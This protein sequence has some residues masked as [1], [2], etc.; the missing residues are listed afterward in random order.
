MIIR[1]RSCETNVIL[2]FW[3]WP[4]PASYYNLIIGHCGK[5]VTSCDDLKWPVDFVS[6]SRPG[7]K[8]ESWAGEDQK[9]EE[10]VQTENPGEHSETKTWTAKKETD[11]EKTGE[12]EK[13][14][15]GYGVKTV[16]HV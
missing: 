13:G 3:D 11:Q 15:T 10:E 14:G 16:T 7:G 2:H 5:I 6:G 12:K 8:E 9:P 4:I 1:L